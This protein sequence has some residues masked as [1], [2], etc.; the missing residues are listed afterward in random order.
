MRK[1]YHTEEQRRRAA[2]ADSTRA[3]AI[4]RKL[5]PE[6][7]RNRIYAVRRKYPD[8]YHFTKLKA[9][10]KNRGTVCQI[11]FSDYCAL[12]HRPC[13]YCGGALPVDGHG[14]D[15]IDSTIGYVLGNLRPCCTRCNQAKNNMTEI[16][17]REW[18]ITLYA[19]WSSKQAKQE[20]STP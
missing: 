4:W 12:A 14:M 2:T 9:A 13:H 18:S 10:A 5:H 15:R 17:F 6:E 3:A 1:K 8:R 11:E 16:A 19:H 7:F 20:N